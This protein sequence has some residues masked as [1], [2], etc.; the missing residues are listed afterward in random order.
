M[1]DFCHT[2]LA[3]KDLGY[4]NQLHFIDVQICPKL[5]SKPLFQEASHILGD[6]L[7]LGKIF[8]AHPALSAM[9]DGEQD[10][11]EQGLVLVRHLDDDDDYD[12]DD[13]D[14]S[15]D[16]VAHCYAIF[17]CSLDVEIKMITYDDSY[18]V[19]SG[20]QSVKIL[21]GILLRLRLPLQDLRLQILD[22]RK[23]CVVCHGLLHGQVAEPAVAG[24]APLALEHCLPLLPGGEAIFL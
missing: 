16:D 4:F 5:S 19:A 12:D 1:H 9:V 7:R 20:K 3:S 8:F 24:E 10:V 2:I 17:V 23:S 11:L 15:D 22:G 14:D 18:L 13:N 21:Q 6:Q